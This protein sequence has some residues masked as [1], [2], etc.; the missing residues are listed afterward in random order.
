[1]TDIDL[2]IEYKK[3]VLYIITEV[4]ING[5]VWVQIGKL[6]EHINII[7]LTPHFIE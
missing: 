2:K 1:M 3:Q 4:F 7:W 6:I 5:T